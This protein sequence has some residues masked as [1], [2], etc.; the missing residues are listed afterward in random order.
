MEMVSILRGLLGVGVMLGILVLLSSNRKNIDWNLVL[1]GI[2]LQVVLGVLIL[3]VAEVRYVFDYISSFFIAVLNFTDEGAKFVFGD[4]PDTVEIITPPVDADPNV[5]VETQDAGERSAREVYRVGMIFAF[6]V[7]PT[8]IFFSALSSLLY[9]LGI[10]QRLIFAFAWVMRRFMRLTG[11]ESLAAAANIFIG[12]TEAPLII[13]PYLPRMSKSEILCLMTGGMAT[14]A[15][16]VFSAFIGF[17]GGADAALQQEFATHLLTASI[18]SAPAAIVAAKILYP[19]DKEIDPEERMEIPKDQVGDNV[20]DAISKGTTDGLRLAVNVGAM[21]I[22]FTALV[23]MLNAIISSGIGSWT[24]LNDY[25]VA[26]TDGRFTAFNLEY[27][28]G[29]CFAPVA[30]VLGV[31]AGADM[32]VVGQL[33]GQKTTINEFYAYAQ[34]EG[35]KDMLSEKSLIITTYALCGF[36]NFASIGIQI[37]GIGAIA[38]SQRKTLSAFGFKSLIGGTIACFLTAAIAG[39]FIGF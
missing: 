35:V 36:A 17:L 13:K 18:M 24:G 31:D 11:A 39:M 8:I 2:L 10:L 20:L 6:K 19:A 4:W 15:G 21:L 34:L 23:A 28:L 26:S 3:K 30:W 16:S 38:P 14:I 22:V 1:K 12:Q 27:L 5:L 29:V 9:Y 33:L 32:L 37:G 7:L 25:V